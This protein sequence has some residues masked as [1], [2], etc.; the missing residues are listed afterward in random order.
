MK[1]EPPTSI[2]LPGSSVPP[3]EEEPKE[4][5]T[6]EDLSDTAAQ[7]VQSAVDDLAVRLD[8]AD[9]QVIVVSHESVTWSDGS[10]GCPQPGMN[11]TQA[12]VSGTRTILSV[13]G[14]D[15]AYHSSDRGEPFLCERPQLPSGDLGN[16]DA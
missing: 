14:V 5:I 16:P 6:I 2:P 4:P 13:D 11:Y 15:F 3:G 12:L 8:V 9:E 1:P 7:I 10:I